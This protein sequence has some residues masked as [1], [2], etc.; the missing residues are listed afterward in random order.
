[1]TTNAHAVLKALEHDL[2]RDEFRP[3]GL[4]LAEVQAPNSDRRADAIW[5]TARTARLVGY[6]IKVTRADLLTELRDPT[7]CEPWLKYCDQWWLAVGDE[8]IVDGLMDQVP[9]DWGVCTPPT[10]AGRRQFKVLR[11]APTLTPADKAPVLGKLISHQSY[12]ALDLQRA[13]DQAQSKAEWLQGQLD[14]RNTSHLE[15]LQRQ[16]NPFEKKFTEVA[17]AYEQ[18]WDK[19]GYSFHERL[20]HVP[21]EVIAKAIIAGEEGEKLTNAAKNIAS[22]KLRQIERALNSLADSFELRHLR[23][24]LIDVEGES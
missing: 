21:A 7:K 1:M 22:N 24:L 16:A 9:A 15:Y 12:R 8:S 17:A 23:D 20:N 13:V 5:M 2:I 18:L 4:L 19:G 6:E 11:P 3:T 10:S 14:K